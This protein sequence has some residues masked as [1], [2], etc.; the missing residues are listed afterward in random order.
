MSKL[1]K[2]V[3]G[4]C[5]SATFMVSAAYADTPDTRIG[6][7]KFQF[8][9]DSNK[10]FNIQLVPAT[11]EGGKWGDTSCDTPQEIKAHT[12]LQKNCTAILLDT[13]M[14]NGAL[15]IS[16]VNNDA[17]KNH[18]RYHLQ[19]WTEAHRDIYFNWTLFNFPQALHDSEFKV[20]FEKVSGD[21]DYP[22]LC[23]KAGNTGCDLV[24][25]VTIKNP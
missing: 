13:G 15:Y 3:L 21:Y 11:D 2:Y 12:S 18:Y 20:A 6:T 7:L 8:H 14:Q 22:R 17:S 24:Y 1:C 9:N 19:A 5:L 16:P 4:L 10:D 25:K 23:M